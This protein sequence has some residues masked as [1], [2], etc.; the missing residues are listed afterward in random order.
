M[1]TKVTPCVTIMICVAG[2]SSTTSQ[3]LPHN[4]RFPPPPDFGRP[5]PSVDQNPQAVQQP[6]SVD[7]PVAMLRDTP[8]AAPVMATRFESVPDA[9]LAGASQA[10]KPE[11]P[12]PFFTPLKPPAPAAA[13]MPQ[14]KTAKAILKPLIAPASPQAVMIAEPIAY[15]NYIPVGPEYFGADSD[16]APYIVS[17]ASDETP[18]PDRYAPAEPVALRPQILFAETANPIVVSGPFVPMPRTRPERRAPGPEPMTAW[19]IAALVPPRP[20]PQP[21]QAPQQ[22]APR[23]PAR[24]APDRTA[25]PVQRK[26]VLDMIDEKRNQRV[27]AQPP[28]TSGWSTAVQKALAET[29]PRRREAGTQDVYRVRVSADDPAPTAVASLDIGSLSGITQTPPDFSLVTSDDLATGSAFAPQP[30]QK[31]QRRDQGVQV[32]A[33]VAGVTTQRSN[34]PTATPANDVRPATDCLVNRGSNG[35]MILIC[36]GVDVSKSDVFR[37]VVEGESAFRGLRSFDQTHEVIDSYGFN[38]ERFNAMSQGPRSARDLAFLRALRKSGKQIR[39]KGRT[40]DLYLM[41]GDKRLATVLIEQ[42]SEVE[43]PASIR[44]N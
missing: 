15:A 33:T 35:R 25:P 13:P 22:P 10:Q 8:P 2:C 20:I 36:E 30:R 19:E 4:A 44:V 31:P 6:L 23:L 16:I 42:V 41:K 34:S 12:K 7:V 26:D 5:A 32:A 21:Q 27:K 38:P 1:S 17:R 9:Y 43:M 24:T 11:P 40:F 18:A 39:I 28:R 3:G 14:Q 29:V 37:A